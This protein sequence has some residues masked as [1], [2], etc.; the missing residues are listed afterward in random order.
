MERPR[1]YQ[2][3]PR[4][5]GNT[6]E[7]RKPNGTLAENGVGKFADITDLALSALR[8]EL[9]I[10]HVWLTGVHAQAT[11]TDWSAIGKPAD[12]AD[13]LKGLAGSPYAIKDCADVCPDYAIDPA[14]R[15]EEF[16]ALVARIHDSGLRVIIDFVAN[17]VARSH[18]STL[19]NFGGRD[20]RSHFFSPQNN[21]F[22]LQPDSPGG[23]PPLRL[24]TV[25]NGERI[26][27]TC[28]ALQAGD[29]FFPGEMDT[30]RVTGNNAATWSP[31]IHDWYETAKLNYGYDFTTGTRAFPHAGNPDAPIPD[32]WLKMDAV[33]AHWQALG[34][35]GFRCDMAHMVP[36]E[37]WAWAI[38]RARQRQPAVTFYAEAYE[39]DPM[40]VEP[41]DPALREAGVLSALLR[42]GFAA[43]YDDPSYKTLKRIY[44]GPAWANDLDGTF[45]A[46]RP[47]FFSNAL[48][49]GENHDEV[50]LAGRGQW[51]DIGMNVGRAVCG[52]LFGIS[53]GP[54]LLYHG[55]EVGE[56]AD[57]AEGFGGDDARTS[58]FDYWSMPEFAK[59]VNEHRF[60][61][62]RLSEAQRDL[63]AFYGR[64]LA[65]IRSPAFRDGAFFPLNGANVWNADFGRLPGEPA[66]GHWL[67][68]YLRVAA[69]EHPP[70]LVVVNLHR[71][72][73]F[74]NVRVILTDEARAALSQMKDGLIL[75]D[76]VGGLPPLRLL[77]SEL[78]AGGLVI[79]ELP[80]LTPAYFEI[81]G[82][83]QD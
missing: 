75:E 37:F 69:P 22:W 2:L 43:T 27:P 54:V 23:G 4:L 5:F 66:S 70:Y 68:A 59:W 42:A 18:A 32:T 81:S 26:S 64:L 46:Q 76:R 30:G 79:P 56:P 12:D 45:A 35:D 38:A 80:P 57:G 48:R 15:L 25:V 49:Y 17:H 72:E 40:R 67:Y 63:R 36:P 13:L 53:R 62:D 61:G 28:R 34:V 19:V 39:N 9:H 51:N 55:Q 14:R 11:A 20:D 77:A 58:I 16:S 52:V 33:L 44:E 71:S 83:A 41:A 60:D 7:R 73:A 65:A 74:R 10:T 6:N 24:P 78:A 3:L 8:D 29:G 31:S 47:E 1:I 82:V 50:R 21:F